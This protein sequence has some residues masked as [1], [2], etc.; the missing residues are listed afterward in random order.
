[1]ALISY[2]L[3]DYD[4]E[5]VRRLVDAFGDIWPDSH[6][7]PMH[8]AIEDY[9]LLDSHLTFCRSLVRGMLKDGATQ[10]EIDAANDYEPHDKSELR[11]SLLLLDMLALI[12]EDKR[13]IHSEGVEDE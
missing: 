2:P 1:M 9:N 10:A 12:P 4:L 7:G 3:R 5:A 13:D 8:I 11:A 6:W